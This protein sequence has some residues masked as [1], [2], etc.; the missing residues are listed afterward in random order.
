MVDPPTTTSETYIRESTFP[1][2]NKFNFDNNEN[3]EELS[4]VWV[5]SCINKTDDCL[6]MANKLRS[7]TNSLITFDTI[8]KCM[9]Y[10]NSSTAEE[11]IFLIVSGDFGEN[12]VPKI[13][14][15]SKIISIY[16]FCYDKIKHDL[17]SNTYKP[18]VQD[19][20]TEKDALFS[21]LTSDVQIQL[22]HFLPMSLLSEDA[23]QRSIKYMDKESV[24]FMWFQLLFK[25]LIHMRHED[26][27]KAEMINL[28]R[29][30]YANS[31]QFTKQIEDFSDKYDP[32]KAIAWYSQ[33][34]FLY[35]LLNRALRT[36]NFD[37][38][39]KFRFYITDLHFQLEK[40]HQQYIQSAETNEMIVYRGQRMSIEDI[41]AIEDNQNAY[42]SVNTF[43]ST[44]TSYITA[45]SFTQ[46]GPCDYLGVI[47]TITIDL[48][49]NNQPFANVKDFGIIP[50]EEEVLFTI[51]TIFR[52]EN[53]EEV[54]GELWS[55]ELTLRNEENAELKELTDSFKEEIGETPTLMHLGNV[56]FY[57]GEYDRAEKYNKILLEH[58][59]SSN[60]NDDISVVYRNIG[61]V[62]SNKA[63]T[64]FNMGIF[65]SKLEMKCEAL[66]SFQATLAIMLTLP[67][68]DHHKL[69]L[70]YSNLAETHFRLDNYQEAIH[71]YEQTLQIQLKTHPV[72]S[73]E[74]AQLYYCIGFTYKQGKLELAFS[75]V[76]KVFQVCLNMHGVLAAAYDILGE[77]HL[78]KGHIDKAIEAYLNKVEIMETLQSDNHIELTKSYNNLGMIYFQQ[79]EYAMALTNFQR[80]LNLEQRTLPSNHP[81][82]VIT[83]NNIAATYKIQN[84][85]SH[86]AEY[87]HK[88]LEIRL[89][90]PTSN[91]FEIIMIYQN[92][93][94][95]Y[96]KLNQ[97]D[98]ALNMNDTARQ[99][100]CKY[101]SSDDLQLI[102]LHNDL[103]EMYAMMD[104]CDQAL[105]NFEK[106]LEIGLKQLTKKSK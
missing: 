60:N 85:Y 28:C 77:I 91:A 14:H 105:E 50:D 59:L 71:N 101:L 19:V 58:L 72:V 90:S 70:T 44:S 33:D 55:V 25:I 1:E 18:K 76:N 69:V 102:S 95:L 61:D 74:V 48:T 17:W 65:R 97:F 99:A 34:T 2:T 4:V 57:M 92:L 38:I 75:N 40:L 56:L 51:G 12:L 26:N 89:I 52:I 64:H 21:K 36:E 27:T 35:R 43:F 103:G 6:D 41:K 5:D 3:V 104:N 47:F 7:I 31:A 49:T 80:T 82:L 37:L 45:S 24:S 79:S 96:F 10:V 63:T 29:K 9:Y 46:T 106:A 53:V 23:K 87:Y 20:F 13:Y 81:N 15:L 66:N 32:N 86:A 84:E 83:Y 62:Y 16:I 11:K 39:Y 78:S 42:I 67:N 68:K 93:S 94:F 54:T 88:E 22:R 98:V 100:V 73:A 30:Q 8:D